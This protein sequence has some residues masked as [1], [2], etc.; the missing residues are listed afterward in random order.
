M[1]KLVLSLGFLACIGIHIYFWLYL[2]PLEED[3]DPAVT[4]FAEP[5]FV[6]ENWPEYANAFPG[7]LLGLCTVLGILS[8]IIWFSAQ[9]GAPRLTIA[10]FAP[11]LVSPIVLFVTYSVAIKHPDLIAG[12]LMA[13]QNGFFWQTMFGVTFRP[14]AKQLSEE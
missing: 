9:E 7:A 3:E 13:F 4:R 1:K 5:H 11:I 12:S 2:F 6:Q 14:K 8:S 10:S